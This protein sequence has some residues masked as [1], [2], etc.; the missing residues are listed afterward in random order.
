MSRPQ[1]GVT[2]DLE[3]VEGT[4]CLGSPVMLIGYFDLAHML[5]FSM[6]ISAMSQAHPAHTRR[7]VWWRGGGIFGQGGSL[8]HIGEGAARVR[9]MRLGAW[10]CRDTGASRNLWTTP[11]FS[12]VVIHRCQVGDIP[13][14]KRQLKIWS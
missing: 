4:L 10:A 2:A 8:G 7:D 12:A 11:I 3:V 1:T 14:F 5:S 13:G 9:S 6:R